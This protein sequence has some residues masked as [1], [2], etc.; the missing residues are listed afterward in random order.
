MDRYSVYST[1]TH[2]LEAFGQLSGGQKQRVLF[3]IAICG[4]PDLL[5]LDEPTVGL[6]VEARRQFWK[7]IKEGS[8]RLCNIWRENP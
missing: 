6:D 5:F 3:A 1:Y 4:N 8:R 2:R 7:V